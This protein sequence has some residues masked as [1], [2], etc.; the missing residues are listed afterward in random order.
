MK[1][2][3]E[4]ERNLVEGGRKR[5]KDREKERGRDLGGGGVSLCE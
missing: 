1:Y 2:K 3:R 5:E 4:K